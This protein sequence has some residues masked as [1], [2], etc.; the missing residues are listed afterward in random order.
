MTI[1]EEIF[2]NTI[3]DFQKMKQF[4]FE[5]YEKNY[6]IHTKICQK[7]FVAIITI[8]DTNQIV[9]K[10][11]DSNTNE[12]F[13]NF[14]I[15]NSE[16]SFSSQVKEEYIALLMKIKKECFRF[17]PIVTEWV[18]PANPKRY[19]VISHFEKQSTIYWRQNRDIKL[20]DIVYIYMAAPISAILFQC[21]VIRVNFQSEFHNTMELR[22]L[23]KYEKEKFYLE[24]LRRFGLSSV[25]CMRKLPIETSCLLHHK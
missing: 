7:E 14:R 22:L 20:H 12:E 5:K 6:Q 17:I 3:P 9:G 11:V 16:G 10:V 15:Q 19:D 24:K 13:Y 18:V 4:G 2:E 25:R 21:E 1:E 23:Q 8:L